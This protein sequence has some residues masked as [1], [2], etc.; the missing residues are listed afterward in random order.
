ML[1]YGRFYSNDPVGWTPSN[2]VMSFNR[3]LYVNNNPY[4]YTD[5]NGEFLDAIVDLGFIAYDLYDTATNGVNATNSASLGANVAGLFIPGATGLGLAA[6]AGDKGVD[7]AN[8]LRRTCCFVAGTQVLTEGGYKNIEDVKLGEK[9]WAK[10]TETGEQDWKPVTKIF[11][12]PDRGI[13]EI[14]L[15]AGDGF[16]QKIQAT[17]D[18]PFYVLGKG[19]KQTIELKAGDKIETD[20]NGSMEVISVIDEQRVDLTYN[21][22]VADFHTYYVTKQ[23]VLVHNC[24]SG[25]TSKTEMVDPKN[26]VPTQSKSEMSGSQVKKL[27]KN[28]EKN[29]FVQKAGDDPVSAVK[30]PATGKLELQDGHHRT[31][32]AKNAKVDKI[33][34]EVWEKSQ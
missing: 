20:G 23:N 32:A 12:E 8:A 26:L 11:V 28:M 10:N 34:V 4:K 24:N 14:K 33:P 22:T 19:W 25:W 3:Y 30:N 16:E 29:G 1:S 5:P 31:A 27:T 17:D 13:F 15:V 7:A 9:L 2:P 18:H 6:R 21:F